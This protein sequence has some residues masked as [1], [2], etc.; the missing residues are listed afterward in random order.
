MALLRKVAFR[1]LVSI[2]AAGVFLSA[3]MKWETEPLE[4]QRFGTADSTQTVRLTLTTGHTV[5]VQAPVIAG[6][7][8]VGM[9][10]P[11]ASPDSQ[12]R[13]SVPLASIT[14]AELHVSSGSP[15]AIALAIVLGIALVKASCTGFACSGSR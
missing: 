1:R 15:A 13:V 14:Q 6:D 7:S 9:Q 2:A 3:C 4:P 8:L 11:D 5:I 12:Q 10:Q